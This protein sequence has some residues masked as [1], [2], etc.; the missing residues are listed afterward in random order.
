V[1]IGAACI[2]IATGLGTEIFQIFQC[3]PVSYFWQRFNPAAKGSCYDPYKSFAILQT[4]NALDI[5][6]D[7]MLA[8]LP[9]IMVW[10]MTMRRVKKFGV[11]ILLGLGAL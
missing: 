4:V 1:A 8:V 6:T 5:V 2:S 11:S 3:T 7:I 9:C 10:N